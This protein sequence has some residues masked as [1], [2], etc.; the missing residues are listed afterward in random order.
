MDVT[1]LVFELVVCSSLTIKEMKALGTTR[2]MNNKKIA[3]AF[4]GKCTIQKHDDF[5]LVSGS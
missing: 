1:I 4:V 5:F 2:T 3:Q